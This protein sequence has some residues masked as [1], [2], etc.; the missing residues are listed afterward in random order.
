MAQWNWAI[1]TSIDDQFKSLSTQIFAGGKLWPVPFDNVD[2]LLNDLDDLSLNQTVACASSRQNG[3]GTPMTT[4]SRTYAKA[5]HSQTFGG[6]MAVEN[7]GH[8]YEDEELEFERI[9]TIVQS[10]GG[11]G[12]NNEER[13][14]YIRFDSRGAKDAAR[15]AFGP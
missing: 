12:R 1:K 7:G 13:P 14:L 8:G 9:N 11:F 10:R 15:R 3:G 6:M 4:R 2:D 5:F